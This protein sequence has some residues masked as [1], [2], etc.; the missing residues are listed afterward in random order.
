MTDT[1]A[2]PPDAADGARQVKTPPEGADS[3]Q[4]R[5][6]SAP[7]IAAATSGS[8]PVQEAG[9]YSSPACLAHEIA[10]GYFGESP[11]LSAQELL[12]LLDRLLQA[13]RAGSNV[14]AAFLD[15]HEPDTPARKLLA[16]V[17]REGERNETLLAEL[18]G[19]LGGAPGASSADFV[20]KA[21]AVQGKAARLELVGRQQQWVADTIGQAL[22]RIEQG[23]ARDALFALRESHLLHV[24]AC[25]ALIETLQA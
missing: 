18:I 11:T 16:A 10:P 23:C 14:I 8:R 25:D 9:G 2:M 19:R 17:L 13:E 15:D 1:K 3:P 6:A 21:L 22:A 4:Q 5:H 24:E 20:P 12:E 7:A